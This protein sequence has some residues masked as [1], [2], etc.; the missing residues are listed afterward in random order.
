M[1]DSI[2]NGGCCSGSV[3]PGTYGN[4]YDVA[5]IT[6]DKCGRITK[7]SN[8]AISGGGGGSSQWT[9]TKGDPIYYVPYVGIGSSVTPTANLQVTGNVYV[10]NAIIT[11]NV[12]ATRYY[13][14]GGLLSNI[15][16][17]TQ[18]LANLV[19]S[20]SV[21]TTNIFATSA[22]IATMNVGYLTVNSAVVYGTSTL[23]VYGTSNLTNVTVRDTLDVLGSMTA[24]AANATFFFDTFTIPYINT[25]YLNV[26]STMNFS[27]QLA[28]FS[29]LYVPGNAN[30]EYLS[31]SNLSVTGNL[32]VTATNLQTTNALTIN[33]SG[34]MTAFKVIQ[35]ETSIHTHN[36]AEFWDATVLAMVIDPEGNVGIHTTSSPGY[37]L[38]VT[39]PANFETLYIRGKSGQTTLNVNGN[40]YASNAISTTNV[41]ATRYY[42]NGGLLSNISSSAITQPF[43]NLVV[44]NSVTTT[45]VFVTTANV[46]TLNVWQISNLSTLSLTNNLYASN[47]FANYASITGTSGSNV[48][49]FSNVSGGSNVFVMNSNGRIGIGTVIPQAP[50]DVYSTVPAGSGYTITNSGGSL[51]INSSLNAVYF[52]VSGTI[53]GYWGSTNIGT[54]GNTIDIG[55]AGN[56][57]NNCYFRSLTLSNNLYASNAVTTTNVF[58]TNVTATGIQTITGLTGLTSLNVTGNVY[59]SNAVTTTNIFTTNVTATGIQTIAGLTGLTSLNVTGNVYVSNAV[60]TTNIFAATETLT[61]TTGQTTLNVTGN[62]YVSN[63][64]TTTNIT[65][66]GFTSNISNTIFNYDTLT[67]PFISCT[68][69]NVASTANVLT[70]SI[71]GST[72]QTSLN[73]TGNLFASNAVTTTNIF[74]SSN[75]LIGPTPT[76]IQA[77]LHVE[78]GSVFIGN[79][80]LTNT[81]FSTTG[82]VYRIRFDN[83]SFS[84]LAANEPNKI[85]LFSNI[86]GGLYCGLGISGASV[87]GCNMNYYAATHHAFYNGAGFLQAG[88]TNSGTMFIGNSVNVGAKLY[89]F[90][91]PPSSTIQC[92]IDS[93]A[94]ALVTSGGGLVGINTLTPTS[95]LHVL[96]NIYASNA[97]TTTN[98]FANTVSAANPIPFRNRLINGGMNIWQRNT[99]AISTTTSVYTTADRWCGALGTSGLILSQWPGPIEAPQFPYAFQVIT[100]TTTSGVPLVEQRIENQNITDFLNG[101]PV[102]VSF[103]VGQPTGTLMPLTVGLYYATAVNNFGTQTLAVAATQNTPTLT[104]ANAYYSLSF[105]LTTSLG[106]TNGL[107]LRFTTG[108]AS[109][110][111]SAFFLTG[112]QVEKGAFAT[113]FEVRPYSTELA[114]AQRYYYQLTSPTAAA[115]GSAAV[116]AIFGTATGITTTAFWLPIQ[117]PVPMRTPNYTLSNSAVT[118]FQL[119]PTGT[120][121][122]T[123][124][125]FQTDSFTPVGATLN[126]VGTNIVPT[127]S[128]IFRTNNLTGSTTAFFGFSCEL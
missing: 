37:A 4:A 11:T 126:F 39:D 20:N 95:N 112:V 18:P 103:W 47:V 124:V 2:A 67:I 23:N 79:A 42:G 117:F 48:F 17:F 122:I 15:S 69:L 19:V 58:T 31:V 83:S 43:A 33:N 109:A 100:S 30:I 127:A 54:N 49:L 99:A 52:S 25:Q 13:G 75:A 77:N 26:A 22:N 81:F 44:S 76:A 115:Q 97:V 51:I 98:V 46:G 101:T 65:C 38:T 9:G 82:S 121:T 8:V 64:V 113:P 80:A 106:A 114:L 56:P 116:Y 45:N 41:F 55:S 1:S 32:Y 34:T 63:A 16:T 84:S 78:Q 35:N 68:T 105:T 93:T 108:G 29:N 50:L 61:G 3:R 96:G 94:I 27:G 7:I 107:S 24:N 111:G 92:R 120:T 57:F 104:T 60:T 72:G 5:Q 73:I 110:T 40:V 90:G 123:S 28:T 74:V 119:L 12:F 6:V 87:N 21:T 86:A 125:G 88:F 10:S 102:S 118:N 14:D 128:Y 53:R 36:V 62:L 91:T 89:I 59:V 70:L 85:V 66:A 71:P